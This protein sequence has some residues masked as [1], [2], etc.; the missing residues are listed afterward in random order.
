M[1]HILRKMLLDFA[2]RSE[3]IARRLRSAA[4]KVLPEKR[5]FLQDCESQNW[6][7][8]RP[9][10]VLSTGRCGTLL[11]NNLLSLSPDAIA[12]HE[13][14]PELSRPSRRAYEQIFREPQIFREVFKSAREEYLLTSVR[15]DKVY[16]ETSHQCTFFAPVIRDV[17]P[18]AVFIHLVRH[19]GNFVRTGIRRKWYTGEHS[20][21]VGRITPLSGG[22]KDSWEKLSLLEKNAWLWNETNQ[23]IEDFKKTIPAYCSL[24]VKAEELFK[25]VETCQEIYRFV[26]IGRF[27]EKKVRKVIRKPVNIQRKGNFPEYKDWPENEKFLLKKMVPLAEEYGYKL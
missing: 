25:N 13:P 7:N 26:G 20:H 18:Q 16:V 27:K 1:K 24:F 2:Y 12:L 10:F 11:L 6:E 19:P 17:F 8:I 9:C 5:L 3:V 14:H 22:V 4:D 21:D 15:Q 23:F